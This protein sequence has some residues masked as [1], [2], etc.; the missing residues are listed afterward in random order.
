MSIA[1]VVN[2]TD[3]LDIPMYAGRQIEALRK[4][5]LASSTAAEE[6]LTNILPDQLDKT[7]AGPDS[8]KK[9]VEW[10]ELVTFYRQLPATEFDQ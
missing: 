3:P 4:K 8:I 9:I 7:G 5:L 6:Y 1:D 2:A 10:R